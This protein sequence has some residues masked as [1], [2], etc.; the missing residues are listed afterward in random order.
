MA[1]YTSLCYD[2]KTVVVQSGG[3]SIEYRV[4][5]CGQNWHN[6]QAPLNSAS[7]SEEQW[8][9]FP[10]LSSFGKKEWRKR[11]KEDGRDWEREREWETVWEWVSAD[12]EYWYCF[13]TT[14]S[15]SPAALYCQ[16]S[17][18]P[19]L[20]LLVIRHT[21]FISLKPGAH[22]KIYCFTHFSVY[23]QPTKQYPHLLL[24]ENSLKVQTL[25]TTMPFIDCSITANFK[26]V[27]C[28]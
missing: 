11:D 20:C 15:S 19:Y 1:Q 6:I 21:L 4:P 8:H 23:L 25:S 18:W 3:K 22:Y 12:F 2:V 26:H 17:Q 5:H 16:P 28:S 24:D 7:D 10:I 14:C 13:I 27:K 9:Q